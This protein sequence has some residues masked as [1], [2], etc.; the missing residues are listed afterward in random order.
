MLSIGDKLK[1][2]REKKALTID[3]IQKQTHIHSTVL[4][5]LEEGRCDE[6]LTSTYVR[7]FLKKYT[8]YLGL[9]SKEMLKEY[10]SLHPE[11]SVENAIDQPKLE[12]SGSEMFTKV[13]YILSFT[14][15]LIA[16]VSLVIL[17]GKKTVSTF[18]K[19]KAAKTLAAPS[20]HKIKRPA[21]A[22]KS[23]PQTK[24]LPEKATTPQRAVIKEAP[25]KLVLK[26]KKAVMV[27]VKNDGI[28]LFKRSLPK[29][30][31]ETFT[32]GDKIELYVAKADAIELTLN[33][34][35]LSL[36]TK[37]TIENLEITAKGIKK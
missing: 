23:A 28:L 18:M 9:D 4:V 12:A 35:T 3:Q 11:D 1:S 8:H 31:L 2:A 32:A 10:A 24:T 29:G 17:V 36:P 15:L 20:L 30:S 27:G 16:C 19:P 37:G 26:V 33:G 13:I 5:A 25:F 14:L 6:I 7:S 34:K 21:A 22:A